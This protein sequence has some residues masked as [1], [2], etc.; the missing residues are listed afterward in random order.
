MPSRIED[1]AIIGD[2]SWEFDDGVLV[3]DTGNIPSMARR[4]IAA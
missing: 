3:F 1:Y 4:Q 2:A